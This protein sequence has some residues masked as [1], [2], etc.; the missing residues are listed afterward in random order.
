MM[1]LRT[2]LNGW[3]TSTRYHEQVRHK[4]LWGC[5]V[6][7][8]TTAHYIVCRR[9]WRSVQAAV[10]EAVPIDPLERLALASPTKAN[11]RNLCIASHAYHTFK[12]DYLDEVV[13]C[14][15][16]HD[17]HALAACSKRVLRASASIVQ[18]M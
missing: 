7:D 15:A 4:C 9:L 1:V 16:R 10:K 18:L 12:F 14:R 2:W 17:N 5:P 13:A 11:F 3:A 8:D 6:G